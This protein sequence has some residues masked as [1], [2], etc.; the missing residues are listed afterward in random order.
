MC[1][2][3][4]FVLAVFGAITVTT[5]II[6]GVDHY[7]EWVKRVN[8]QGERISELEKIQQFSEELEKLKARERGE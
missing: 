8:S 3:W 7:C 2:W 6:A 4:F 1:E 5:F